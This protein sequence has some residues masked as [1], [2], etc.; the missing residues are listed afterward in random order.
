MSDVVVFEELPLVERNGGTPNVVPWSAVA[1]AVRQRPGEWARVVDFKGGDVS[2]AIRIRQGY[3]RWFRP[4]GSF[5]AAQRGPLL[6]V[7]YVGE[8]ADE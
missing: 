3:A 6:Y 7:R 1:V 4:A 5:E 2:A 8:K